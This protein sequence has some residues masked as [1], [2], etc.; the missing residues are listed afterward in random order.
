MPRNITKPV[1]KGGEMHSTSADVQTVIDLLNAV[2]PVAGGP[3]RNRPLDKNALYPAKLIEA[4]RRFQLQ[5]FGMANGRVNPDDVTIS[6]LNKYDSGSP[7]GPV[8]SKHLAVLIRKQIVDVASR[9]VGTVSNRP[10]ADGF[11][12]GWDQLAK[13]LT[14]AGILVK[15]AKELGIMKNAH[16]LPGAF[17][18]LESVQ[19]PH[20]FHGDKGERPG[21][22]QWC[23]IFANW[24]LNQ[25]SFPEKVFNLKWADQKMR[26]QNG[27]PFPNTQVVD[28]VT[29]AII[30]G[31]VIIVKD[32]DQAGNY[33]WHH[34]IVASDP[35]SDGRF[36]VVEGN[37]P[38]KNGVYQCIVNTQTRFGS[39]KRHVNEVL[40]YYELLQPVSL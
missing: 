31:D 32:K 21:G 23:G 33:I 1:G 7:S 6:M 20:K 22:Y 38:D 14:G 2:P 9:M 35:G 4:I 39:S 17:A 37:F 18:T 5:E 8:T 30:E 29:P 25:V 11:R 3:E 15:P 34:V 16:T 12:T 40:Y 28:G 36:D 13:I 26:F 10:G 19:M 24:V 27:N